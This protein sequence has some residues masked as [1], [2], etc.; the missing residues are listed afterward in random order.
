MTAQK[1]R[2]RRSTFV[3]GWAV[4][5]RVLLVDDNKANQW[6]HVYS[7]WFTWDAQGIPFA[8]LEPLSWV[9]WVWLPL[10]AETSHA[11]QS[12]P[13]NGSDPTLRGHPTTLG[14]RFQASARSR[15]IQQL[16]NGSWGLRRDGWLHQ[17]WLHSFG[18]CGLDCN[19]HYLNHQYRFIFGSFDFLFSYNI[20]T[21]E[22][23]STFEPPRRNDVRPPLLPLTTSHEKMLSHL[24]SLTVDPA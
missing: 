4:P 2:V 22:D 12:H 19:Y 1:L 9:Y 11:P 8:L 16:I 6:I 24:R 18:R 20:W 3:P 17:P 10:S 23:H 13:A 14:Q 15:R 21:N 7:R 5:P